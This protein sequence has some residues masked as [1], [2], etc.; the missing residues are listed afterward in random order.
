M[1]QEWRKKGDSR[2][3]QFLGLDGVVGINAQLFCRQ[4]DGLFELGGQEH[5]NSTQE[6]KVG[7][8]SRNPSQEAVQVIHGQR[9]DLLL[10]LLLLTDL[11]CGEELEGGG[12]NI[13]KRER[14]KEE[15]A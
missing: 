2:Y 7:L 14:K 8:R 6:L 12:E 3:Q 5:A 9:E 1:G 11:Q 10:T 13:R 15:K 4:R